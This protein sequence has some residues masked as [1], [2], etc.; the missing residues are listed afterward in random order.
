VNLPV[1]WAGHA[2]RY[3]YALA[4][5]L[6]ATALALAFSGPLGLEG[7][8]LLAFPMGVLA[9]AWLG[10]MGPGILSALGA[11]VAIAIF[12]AKPVGSLAIE[13]PKERIALAVFVMACVIESTVV[14]A[15]QRS[16]RGLSRLTEAVS[17]SEE[18]Y[19]LLFER[20]PEPMWVFD[21]KTHAIFGANQAALETYG[22]QA[23]EVQRMRIDA[24][25]EAEDAGR[26]VVEEKGW[27][28][29][30]WRHKTKNGEELDVQARC[31]SAPW[32]AGRAC[33]MV[34][35][36][37]TAQHRAEMA[38]R[39]TTQELRRAKEIA[40][41]AT[42]ARDRFLV[43][44]SHELRTPLT[45]ALLA[46]AALETRANVPHDIR[47]SMG[48]IRDKVKLEA[49]LID[50]LVDVARIINGDFHLATRPVDATPI[51]TRAIDE[52]VEEART[53][54]VGLVRE[55]GPRAHV[56]SVDPERLQEAVAR[57]IANAIDATPVGSAVRVSVGRE[58]RGEVVIGIRH[59]G[60]GIDVQR[61]F[62]PFER[63]EASGDSKAW[64][65]AL[66][67]AISK[68]IAEACGGG[69][70]ASFD[71]EGTSVLMRFPAAHGRET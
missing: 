6:L 59:H 10:G 31:A 1:G 58:A 7:V 20:N 54:G 66:G 39:A 29:G 15:S 17:A 19:R 25:F 43:V 45:P 33:L 23:D 26:F 36:D 13:S 4:A 53:K 27:D 41:G 22:Y 50:D 67:R 12:F 56:V 11:A 65:L 63:D 30:P 44:L 34:V 37:V 47:R 18:K 57:L 60:K 32:L 69:V 2:A 21:T 40:E 61:M 51:V 9:A 70:E 28:G 48:L 8:G 46:S 68:G 64:E 62:D 55:L 5:T 14:G 3:A 35:H 49:R 16:E 71:G 24:L 38:L 42:K 52:C